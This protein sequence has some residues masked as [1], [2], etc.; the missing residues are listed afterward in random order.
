MYVGG[1][2]VVHAPS[3][4]ETVRIQAIWGDGLIGAGRP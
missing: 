3:T 2:A 4:G 1:G